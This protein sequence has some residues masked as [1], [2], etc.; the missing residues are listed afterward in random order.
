LNE[1]SKAER[2]SV[3]LTAE[4]RHLAMVN[5][6]VDPELLAP[7]VPVGT[8]LDTW[9]GK[10]LVSIVGFL[11]CDTRVRGVAVPFHR[12]FEEVNL[13]FYVR[14]T[15]EEGRRRGVVFVRELVPRRAVAWIARL[16]YN[17]N[18]AVARMGHA[19]RAAGDGPSTALSVAYWWSRHGRRSE[20]SL[21]TRGDALLPESGSVEEFVSEHFWGYA[22]RRQ[23]GT[24]EYRVDHPRWTVRSVA[25]ARVN[26][27][28]RGLYGAPF[29]GALSGRPSSAF[30]ADGSEVAVFSGFP[31][32]A[33]GSNEGGAGAG[34]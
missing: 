23:G 16:L 3:F 31:L 22:P 20:M 21:E 5:Y 8:E 7:F 15:A 19:V 14:R 6:D 33:R 30:L 1:P 2:R 29:E 34:R 28:V 32:D 27:D 13:R 18:Y 12:R 26:L 24:L 25:E 10:C 4:W 11:F 9:K 17:E